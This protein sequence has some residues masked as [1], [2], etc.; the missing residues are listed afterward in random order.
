MD[1]M[2]QNRSGLVGRKSALWLSLLALLS[3]GISSCGGGKTPA[4]LVDE[5]NAALTSG[6]YANALTTFEAA[7]DQAKASGPDGQKQVFRAR[8]GIVEA[9]AKLKDGETAFA[10][11]EAMATE[12]KD[13]MDWKTY[14]RYASVMKDNDCVKQA[15][16]ILGL[17][18]SAFPDMEEKFKEMGKSIA[19]NVGTDSPE[20]ERLKA[21][22]YVQ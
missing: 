12:H 20:M 8:K 2:A 13:M 6:D 5:G 4:A 7:R 18:S 16:E 10:E 9:T 15:I 3:L 19:E 17:G 1:F 21:L 14:Q 22:G 11:F